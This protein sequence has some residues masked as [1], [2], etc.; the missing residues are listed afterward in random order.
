[1]AGSAWLAP[2]ESLAM[3][4]LVD[5]DAAGPPALVE[6]NMKFAAYT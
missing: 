4:P 2:G 3:E 5:V 1:M 6:H